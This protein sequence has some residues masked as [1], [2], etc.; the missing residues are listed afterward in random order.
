MI[1]IPA[2]SSSAK[3]ALRKWL[4][5]SGS[6]KV[7]LRKWLCESGSAKVALRKWLCE[8]GSAKVAL[9]KWLCESG[10]AKVAAKTALGC[11]SAEF[12]CVVNAAPLS[13]LTTSGSSCSSV[14]ARH[15]SEGAAPCPYWLAPCPIIQRPARI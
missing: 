7:A 12:R 13:V 3:V 1:I 4:C 14:P 9:R 11:F 2:R 15:I 10:S 5:E 6:A 8:S